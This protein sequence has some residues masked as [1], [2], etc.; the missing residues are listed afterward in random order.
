VKRASFVAAGAALAL[1]P[2]IARAEGPLRVMTLP[3]DQGA[4]C[5]YAQDLGMFKKAGLDAQV[6]VT[7]FGT[8]VAAAVAGGSI[9]IG[10]SNIMSLAAAFAQGLP[11]ALIAGA[12][13]Y[14]SAKPT[15]MMIVAKNSPLKTAKDLNGKTVAVNGLK[16]ITQISVQAWADQNGGN[17]QSIKF[18]EMPFVEMEG[19]LMSGRIDMAL[20][21]DPNA[22]TLL[23]GGHTRPFGKA[24]D[25]I[26]KEFLIGGWFAKTDWIAA[27]TDTVKKFV[28]VMREAA[29]WANKPADFAQ[30][31]AILEKY[32]KVSVGAANRVAYAERLD[33]ALIQP[34]IDTAAKYGI[35]KTPFPAAKMISTVVS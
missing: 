6:S 22:T 10:Q 15:S 16:S 1:V 12:G 33:P 26:G 20:L 30:S 23:A 11:F 7:N 3:I 14:S 5:F 8:Q 21:A 29:Q 34:S 4:Q 35:L 28:A 24:F 18:V 2:R 9:E 27:N 19:A 25:A 32:T 13:L 31:A 17:S